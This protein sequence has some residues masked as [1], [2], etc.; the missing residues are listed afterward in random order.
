MIYP[1]S[2]IVQLKNEIFAIEWL[3]R[4]REAEQL[5]ETIKMVVI[6]AYCRAL[7]S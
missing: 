4:V 2:S 5:I 7:L 3:W 1:G 6:V